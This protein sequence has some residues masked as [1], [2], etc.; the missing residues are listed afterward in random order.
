MCESLN[1]FDVWRQWWRNV[2]KPSLRTSRISL[3]HVIFNFIN[4]LYFLNNSYYF[5]HNVYSNPSYMGKPELPEKTY[6]FPVFIESFNEQET[7][8]W[9]N[10]LMGEKS[11]LWELIT[12]P[13][14]SH[15]DFRN[16]PLVRISFWSRVKNTLWFVVLHVMFDCSLRSTMQALREVKS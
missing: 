13:S 4:H 1:C 5:L 8:E 9:I 12:P 2:R 15:F 3:A 7:H 14:W 11:L 16:F 10:D 6:D